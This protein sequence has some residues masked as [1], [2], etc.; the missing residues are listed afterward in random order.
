MQWFSCC[1]V[2]VQS[3]V[4]VER[5]LGGRLLVKPKQIVFQFDA[6]SNLC[7]T[8]EDLGSGWRCKIP[9][10]CQVQTLTEGV[11]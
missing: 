6:L 7:V 9:H 8:I 11:E 2:S 1:D 10:S 4:E 5:R 3:V